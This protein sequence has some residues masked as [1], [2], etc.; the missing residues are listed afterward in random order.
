MQVLINQEQRHNATS[1]D[2]EREG[3]GSGE[4]GDGGGAKDNSQVY[5]DLPRLNIRLDNDLVVQ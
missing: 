2:G 3:G 5:D 1:M 4:G